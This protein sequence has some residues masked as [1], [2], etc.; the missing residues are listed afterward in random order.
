MNLCFNQKQK[1]FKNV[2]KKLLIESED[3]DF[4]KK[5]NVFSPTWCPECRLIRRMTWRNERTL[6]KRKCDLC[7][8][9]I[10]SIYSP[11]ENLT[12]YCNECWYSD[13]WD[14]LAF[15]K[16]YDFSFP[17]FKQFEELIKKVPL[18]AINNFKSIN[19]LYTNFAAE[20]KDCFL[21]ISAVYNE[22]CA[23]GNRIFNS[24]DCFDCYD[25]SKNYFCYECFKVEDS[26]NSAYLTNSEAIINSVFCYDCKNVSDC[27]GCVNLRNKNYFIFNQSYSKERFL[28]KKKK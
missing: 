22:N 15:G 9:E 6:Y 4:Y 21:L 24:K 12:V 28:E 13:K 14:P 3:F 18:L 8:K 7:R 25:I 17:F 26:Y 16:N 20:N 27:I 2:K 5:N 19:S 1:S 10:I 23:Y 11:N